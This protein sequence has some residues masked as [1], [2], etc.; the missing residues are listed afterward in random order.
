MIVVI[1]GL[2]AGAIVGP[3]FISAIISFMGFTSAGVASGSVAAGVQSAIYGGTVGTGSIFAILQS[4]GAVGL[5]AFGWL[6]T[7][8]GGGV[9]GALTALFSLLL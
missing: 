4:V 3:F 1:M 2:L 8:I 5:G 6:G 7:I 9:V